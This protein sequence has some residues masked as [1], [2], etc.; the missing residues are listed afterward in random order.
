MYLAVNAYL[1]SCLEDFYW[2]KGNYGE[3]VNVIGHENHMACM[4]RQ[5]IP[6]FYAIEVNK[7]E[8]DKAIEYLTLNW[9]RFQNGVDAYSFKDV[10]IAEAFSAGAWITNSS[11]CREYFCLKGWLNKYDFIY[12]SCNE[13]QNFIEIARLFGLRVRI[14]DPIH[15]IKPRLPSFNC[16]PLLINKTPLY[17]NFLRYLQRPFLSLLQH[18]TIAIKDWTIL[19]YEKNNLAGYLLIH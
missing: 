8:I 10:S 13:S 2:V 7:S 18:K 12:I 11:I 19:E 14:F 6:S 5:N 16:R 1:I 3:E 17:I 9:H 15:R 4:A